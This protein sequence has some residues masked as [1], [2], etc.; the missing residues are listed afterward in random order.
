M[1]RELVHKTI[2][3]LLV[4]LISALFLGMIRQFLMPMFMAALFAAIL[5]PAHR[6]L[7]KKLGNRTNLA[8][9]LIIAGIILLVLIPL[10]LF[11]GVVVAQA[12]SVSQSITPWVQSFI[13]EPTTLTTY[14]QKLPYYEQILPY[15]TLIIE[16]AGLLVGNVSTFLINS[17]SEV[18]KMTVGA[19]FSS[20]IMLYAMFYFLTIGETL[21]KKILYFLPLQD[22]DEQRLLHRF[23]S[24]TKATLKGTLI[25]GA[26][27]GTVCGFAFL[28]AGIQAPVFWGAMMAVLSIIPAFGTA[29]IW[30]PAL[31]LL[32]LK[33]E[34]LG[35]GILAVLCGAIAGNLDNIVRP[36]LVG[37]D[38]E[39]HDLL[40]LFG[41]LGGI[42]M[43]GILGIIIGP[44]IA[45]LFTT[46]WE[47]YGNVFAD[48]LPEVGPLF[49]S[50]PDTSTPEHPS[51]LQPEPV[52]STPIPGAVKEKTEPPAAQAGYD[53][54]EK[55][56]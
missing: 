13:N 42:T 53:T 49:R 47:I 26:L 11:I 46:I 54:S 32:A 2:L 34:F 27:Q 31:I 23:T 55:T 28:L 21:L 14:M 50:E 12:V 29:I 43:F 51:A 7:T 48:Y 36:R 25:I 16:K 10:S 3:L 52:E 18:T 4:L 5:S 9:I 38:T 30:G 33:G 37:K 19:V 1:K 40:I 15:R 24:V 22:S 39:L 17:L 44:I 45:A 35:V 20:I 8:S 56:D 41:T 6:W